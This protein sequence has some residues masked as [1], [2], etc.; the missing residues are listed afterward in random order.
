MSF[1]EMKRKFWRR[2]EESQQNLWESREIQIGK[3]ELETN[4]T[5]MASNSWENLDR[6]LKDSLENP[7]KNMI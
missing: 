6:M 1:L 5:R 3:V 2:F 7:P 4:K